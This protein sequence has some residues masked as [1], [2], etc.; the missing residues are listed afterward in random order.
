MVGISG[1][2]V[3]KSDSEIQLNSAIS[4]TRYNNP[5]SPHP[6]Y[7]T[8]LFPFDFICRIKHSD[9]TKPRYRYIEPI[10]VA[11]ECLV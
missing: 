9:M 3:L 5:L 4:S 6:P 11:L 8:A 10:S 7:Q 2:T 1:N